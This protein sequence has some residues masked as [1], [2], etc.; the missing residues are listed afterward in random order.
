[1]K[2][3]LLL[4]LATIVAACMMC[5]VISVSAGIVTNSPGGDGLLDS[6]EL[7]ATSFITLED[8]DPSAYSIQKGNSTYVFDNI[9]WRDALIVPMQSIPAA[10]LVDDAVGI[11]LGDTVNLTI[12]GKQDNSVDVVIGDNTFNFPGLKLSGNISFA[13]T[14]TGNVNYGVLTELFKVT[15]YAL[16][17]NETTEAVNSSFEN[18]YISDLKFAVQ[19]IIAPEE[20]IIK[21]DTTTHDTWVRTIIFRNLSLMSDDIVDEVLWHVNLFPTY[22]NEMQLYYRQYTATTSDSCGGQELYAPTGMVL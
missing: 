4:T 22:A 21:Q 17:E 14:G 15:G 3:K 7:N 12:S 13:Q 5:S 2:K 1:M 20:Y 16:V 19:S 6:G 9:I 10:D 11:A 18:D 8:T